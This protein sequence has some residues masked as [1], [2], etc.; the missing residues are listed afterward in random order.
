MNNTTNKLV[1][2]PSVEA[3]EL[4]VVR[5][6]GVLDANFDQIET[7]LDQQLDGY[8]LVQY[9]D[10]ADESI[11]QMRKDRA[12]L[13][14]LAASIKNTKKEVKDEF[15]APLNQFNERA[16]R[17]IALIE[18][19]KTVI[20]EKIKELEEAGREAKRKAIREY[21]D[22]I[23][24]NV[25]AGVDDDFKED[26]YRRLY[27]PSWENA[28]ATQKAYKE[29]LKKGVENFTYGM[30]CLKLSNHEFMEDGIREFKL[31]LDLSAAIKVMEDKQ[32]QKE[33]LLRKEQER[34]EEERRRIEEAA[35]A[36][37]QRKIDEANAE[38]QRK[39]EEAQKRAEEEA[40]RKM[41]AQMQKVV[42]ETEKTIS[43]AVAKATMEIEKKV[44]TTTEPVST[45]NA[46]VID[47]SD[48]LQAHSLNMPHIDLS[49]PSGTR[50][51]LVEFDEMD[52]TII[53][54]YADRMNVKYTVKA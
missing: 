47:R 29:G 31:N 54:K 51:V 4:T 9:S 44:Q 2:T 35:Q 53:Q 50:K 42:A 13:N 27:N 6:N 33:E 25:S 15:M 14:R 39:I 20:D 32:A 5:T 12:D 17:L 23:F 36:E 8:R 30:Q 40:Q 18:E 7:F 41:E 52:W 22:S 26:L 49:D 10:N 48:R 46:T 28:T 19:P 38:A 45:V 43:D 34:L 24:D 3:L 16:D 37:A 1:T 21:F 11:R